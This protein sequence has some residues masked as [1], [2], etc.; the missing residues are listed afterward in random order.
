MTIRL[1]ISLSAQ[2][3][4][5]YETDEC[6]I[7]ILRYQYP[8]STAANGAG[9]RNGSFQT[10]RG[11]HRIAEKIGA[12]AEEYAVFHARKLTGEIWSPPIGAEQPERDWILSRI[13]WLAG[14]EL[15]KNLGAEVDTQ[16]RYIYIHGTAAEHLV[17]TA[18]SHGCIRM[19]NADIMALF[20]LV[21]TGTAVNIVD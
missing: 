6:S 21:K 1:E 10:P 8:V 19:K 11:R 16:S 20:D 18:V 4:S 15:G 13:L 5:V 17:G 3:L 9:E 12:D 7:D 2:W 14:C